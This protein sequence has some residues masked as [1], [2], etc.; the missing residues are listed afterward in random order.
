MENYHNF[1]TVNIENE[2]KTK[3]ESF[4]LLDSEVDALSKEE[5]DIRIALYKSDLEDYASENNL[6]NLSDRIQRGLS[7]VGVLAISEFDDLLNDL[8][9]NEKGLEKEDLKNIIIDFHT[10]GPWGFAE[11]MTKEDP[12]A[13]VK[14]W[15][16]LNAISSIDISREK[17]LNN[18]EF[19]KHFAHVKY[20]LKEAGQNY[21]EFFKISKKENLENSYKDLRYE[22]GIPISEMDSGFIPAALQGYEAGIVQD[23]DGTPMIGA[24]NEIDPKIFEYWGLEKKVED[25]GRGRI[26][27]TYYNKNG[28]KLFRHLYP[29]FIIVDA[30]KFDLAAAIVRATERLA[31]GVAIEDL[32]LPS[33]E[34]LGVTMYAPTSSK[35]M[36]SKPRESEETA[37][38]RMSY[39]ELGK[40]KANFEESINSETALMSI[41]GDAFYDGMGFIKSTVISLDSVDN[42]NKKRKEKG[43]SILN[44]EERSH[45]YKKVSE[46]VSQKMEELKYMMSVIEPELG[47]L[48][49]DKPVNIMDMAGGAGDLALAVSINV[50]AKGMELGEVQIV[51]PFSKIAELDH[52]TK[53]MFDYIPQGDLL[54]E[55]IKHTNESIQE[56]EIIEDA[57]VVA[58]HSCG[59]L[60]DSIIEKWVQSTSPLLVIMTCCQDKACGLPA[61]YNISQEN[62]NKWCK[63]SSRT[64]VVL[65]LE[66]SKKY[67]KLKGKLESGKKAMTSLDQARVEYLRRHGFDAELMQTDKFPKGDVIIARRKK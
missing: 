36:I 33:N 50:I 43:K 34:V 16:I 58:K 10:K 6:S 60:A 14:F 62:W 55:K 12:S 65:P 7:T 56:A 21:Q 64:N 3:E 67:D 46:K 42:I 53:L 8:L 57:I 2:K 20:L 51:D 30:K 40:Y 49:K 54:R 35:E 23:A 29:G 19:L 11:E 32:E 22:D 28:Q 15:M 38:G 61:R 66:T 18:I 47:K 45:N 4:T 24:K 44:E 1:K 27:D 63:E 9:K 25:D 48:N 41:R 39:L 5:I 59:D 13:A 26:V 17:D 37:K 31:E 52:F